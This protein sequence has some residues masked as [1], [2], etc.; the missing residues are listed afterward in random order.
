MA[1]Q[2]P[3]KYFILK[4]FG[5]VPARFV[6]DPNIDDRGIWY[7]KDYHNGMC[8]EYKDVRNWEETMPENKRDQVPRMPRRDISL[9]VQGTVVEDMTRHFIQY[10]NFVKF[11]ISSAPKDNLLSRTRKFFQR[12]DEF[13]LVDKS[14]LSTGGLFRNR[15]RRDAMVIEDPKE[16]IPPQNGA[17]VFGKAI[18]GLLG[19]FKIAQGSKKNNPNGEE[20]DS[21]TKSTVQ[22]FPP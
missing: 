8:A 13:G 22:F 11:D 21:L 15:K 7:G 10:W 4:I 18:G 14:K 1:R 16:F 17:T 19:A 3:G 5:K 2:R 12:K 20:G 9:V 6:S